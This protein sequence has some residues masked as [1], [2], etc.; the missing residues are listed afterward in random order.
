MPELHICSPDPK[1]H[2]LEISTLIN[3]Q[4]D[5]MASRIRDPNHQWEISRMGT[6]DETIVSFWGVWDI[7][8]RI[9]LAQIPTGGVDAVVTHPDY[10]LRGYMR[11][12]GK[13][14]LAS[15][16]E[17]GYALSILNGTDDFFEKFGYV[18]AWPRQHYIL[19]V[20]QLPSKRPS[21]ILEE[22]VPTFRED[23]VDLYNVE[24]TMLTGTA[25]R[26]TFR[27]FK[28]PGEYTGYLWKDNTGHTLGYLI[29]SYQ[30]ADETQTS[31]M[32]VDAAGDPEQIMML[33]GI[34][35]RQKGYKDVVFD[36][37]PYRSRLARYLRHQNCTMKTAYKSSGDCM[38]AIM[39]FG[40]LMTQLTDELTRRL[41]HSHLADWSG[42][43]L[44]QYNHDRVLLMIHNGEVKVGPEG[45]SAH[46]IKG[47]D[48]ITQLIVGKEDP[49]E[50]V[51]QGEIEITGDARLL[52][53]VLFPPQ[54]PQI[55]AVDL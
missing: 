39:N 53:K 3:H 44:I 42:D 21:Y 41:V 23:L 38:V 20:D 15:M 52:I 40:A 19:P 55:A 30:P 27:T 5:R 36:R 32:C 11:Q 26:P 29:G 54:H 49:M 46:R 47:G 2:R 14:I 45:D 24:N 33:L 12:I 7:T 51:E 13:A 48:K 10:R 16:R 17:R 6:V 8:L 22:F 37:W 31:F 4:W 9:G 18:S 34:L 1:I 35:T 43:L 50:I 28:W 25:I